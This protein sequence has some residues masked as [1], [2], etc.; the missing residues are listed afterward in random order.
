MKIKL[1]TILN[2]AFGQPM[3]ALPDGK[4]ANLGNI[5]AGIL[6]ITEQGDDANKKAD[7]FSVL[8]KV[9]NGAEAELTAEDIVL[10]KE[11]VG[12]FGMTVVY[13]RVCE[14]LKV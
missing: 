7:L 3:E 8:L 14:L 9:V 4:P 10:V 11:R 5:L 6:Q 2:D 13:G 1:N 12:K